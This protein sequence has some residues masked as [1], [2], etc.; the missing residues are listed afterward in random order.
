MRGGQPVP[1]EHS[2]PAERLADVRALAEVGRAQ[3]RLRQVLHGAELQF[4]QGAGAVHDSRPRLLVPRQRVP[5]LHIDQQPVP[6][7]M[8]IARAR[9]MNATRTL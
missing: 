9:R 7:R 3:E 4:G 5:A 8:R 6:G 1:A 2:V